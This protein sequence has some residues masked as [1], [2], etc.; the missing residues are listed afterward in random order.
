MESRLGIG[1]G[2]SSVVTLG[3]YLVRPDELEL[4]SRDGKLDLWGAL[5]G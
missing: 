1:Q 5:S 4:Y 2:K 3:P